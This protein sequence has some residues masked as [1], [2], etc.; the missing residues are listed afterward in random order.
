MKAKTKDHNKAYTILIVEDSP[1]Q[2]LQVKRILEEE[3]FITAVCR[4]GKD[5]LWYLKEHKPT[6]IIS[7]IVMPEMDGYQ[8]CSVIKKDETL[9]DIP[10]ILLTALTSPEDVI[11]G[12][13]SGAD[14]FI[15]K[16][17]EKEFLLSRIHYILVNQEVRRKGTTEV[18]LNIYFMGQSHAISSNR[19]QIIDLLLSTYEHAVFQNQELKKTH[20]ELETLNKQLEDKVNQRTQ[21][22]EALNSVLRAI[23][24]VNQLIVREKDR[25]RLVKEAC[26][27]LTTTRESHNAWIALM[28]ESGE[29]V[30]TAEA[31]LGKEFLSIQRLLKGGKLVHCARR[32]L[33]KSGVIIIEN[34]STECPDCPLAK[35]SHARGAMAVRL[36]HGGK[37]YGLLSIS[38]PKDL[39]RN[40]EE[41]SLF[42][43][44][45]GDI[46]FAL[47][48]MKVEAERKRAEQTL[49]AIFQSA[50][51]GILLAD[52]E[53]GRFVAANEAIRQMLGY[54]PE[55]IKGL[56]VADIQPA[57]S[58]EYV[59]THFDKQVRGEITLAPDIPVKRKDGSVF[60]SDVSS[61]PLKLEGRLHLIGIFRDITKRKQ[62]EEALE[63]QREQLKSLFDYSGEAITLLDL[64]NHI[65]EA[66]PG[67]EKIFGY[68]IDE[69]RG[70]VIED[71]I[72]PERFYYMESKE[73]DEQSFKGIKG[74]EIIRR[75]K[76]GKEINVRVSAG[77]I[78]VRGT[79]VGRFVVFDDITDRK[80]AEENLRHERDFIAR[81]METSPVCITVVN[82]KGQITFA[83]PGAEE[84]LGLSPDEVT[85]RTYNSPEWRITD[86]DGKPF[87]DE[88]LP[89]RQV[90]DT[91]LPV[92]DVR[93]AI[94]WPDGRRVLL[95]INGAP[96]FDNAGKLE[97]MICAIQDVTEQIQISKSLKES[98]QRYRTLFEQSKDPIY[99]S[100]QDS[101]FLDVNH[102]YL[103]LFGYNKEEIKSLKAEEVYKSPNDRSR[104]KQEVEKEGF[105]KDFEVKLIKKD[106]TEMDCLM[107]STIR[108]AEDGSI[109]GYQGIIRDITDFKL[110]ERK[111]K[112]YAENLETMVEERTKELNHA[113]Y[114]TEQ[115]RDRID[116]I[117]KSVGDGLIV[118]DLY[119][120]V[121]LMNRAAE[122]LLGVRLSDIINRPIDFAIEDKTLRERIK[123]TLS[124]KEEG[125][126]FDFELPGKDG[127][128]PR[129]IRARTSMIKDKSGAHTGI[130]TAMHDVTYERE[131]DRM[132]TEF[133]STAAHELRTPLTSIQGFS[134]LL[135]TRDD[136]T[137][138]EKNEC[139]SYINT[140]SVNL[141]NIIN[142]LLDISRIES[143]K[144]FSLNK[145]PCNINE[146][147]RETVPYFQMH[148]KKH[149]FDLILPEEPL[150][151]M[152]D[153]GKLRQVFENILSN[154]V[155]YSPEGGAI[156][157][158]AKLIGEFGMWNGQLEEMDKRPAIEVAISDEGMGMTPDQVAKIFDKFYRAD[159]SNTPIPGT[160]LGMSIVKYLVEA[161]GGEVFVESTQGKGTR[162]RF[163]IPI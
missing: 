102:A 98:E 93:H 4:N 37:T 87:P 17:Y 13:Q 113:L 139:L 118:T 104:F 23:R 94:E 57:E 116:G 134:E 1:T 75:R 72:C 143:G 92:Y 144:G 129:I 106:G 89:F 44:V 42:E 46:A 29:L 76:D 108:K 79:I 119:N 101:A 90:M 137:E 128:N 18:G 58:L 2:A 91:G 88:Q 45:V 133:I 25:D 85:G 84:V 47:H 159:Y 127:E 135:T 16:P 11:K 39:V 148:S 107:T 77:P 83:N 111:I 96:L 132:K 5:A 34:P 70:K 73:L 19:M 15:T 145:A 141:A 67:F 86:Y 12:L 109:L 48:N 59:R 162:V 97:G 64:E 20:A 105:V 40:K 121:I 161:H 22:I 54:S 36:E 69:A 32:A 100:T 27:I 157:L 28:D 115:A 61:A 110:A 74:A 124:K 21:R 163:T 150:E 95:S 125:Y 136:I 60:L 8:L 120:R 38:I 71:L 66:N 30:A 158:E 68:S 126:Q 130:I 43:E 26:R 35:E 63:E 160:G 3:G 6:I 65:I 7:D 99:L 142:D 78:K 151:A 122:D 155:K 56:S 53:S 80:H 31:G 147:M 146:L 50:S 14:N 131:V 138:E 49:N 81:I 140:Q 41:L 123:N 103:D 82:S 154:A 153:P 149:Q 24:G 156:R 52:V 51:D 114:D 152:V 9:R 55:E 62:A 10:V 117:L 112:D 33:K